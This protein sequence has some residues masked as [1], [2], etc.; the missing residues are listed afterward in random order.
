MQ[1]S[2]R[3]SNYYTH[4]SILFFI[5]IEYLFSY[6][7]ILYLSPVTKLSGASKENRDG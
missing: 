7:F 6:M 4:A 5:V 3:L 1:S 2:S